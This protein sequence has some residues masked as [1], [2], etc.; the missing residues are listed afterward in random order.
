MNYRIIKQVKGGVPYY[1][2]HEVYYSESEKPSGYT[3]EPLSEYSASVEELIQDLELKLSDA[4]R[5]RN[6]VL[7]I[8]QTGA[9]IAPKAFA[10]GN[11]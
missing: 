10:A 4:M 8:D 9:L 7:E 11:G 2:L 1:G 3:E 5:F 6:A